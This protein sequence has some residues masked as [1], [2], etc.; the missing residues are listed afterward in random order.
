MN[1]VLN[2]EASFCVEPLLMHPQSQ[3]LAALV[4]INCLG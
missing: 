4:K 1:H 2:E 3:T